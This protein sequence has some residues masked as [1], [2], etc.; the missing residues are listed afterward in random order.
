MLY[1]SFGTSTASA[2]FVT[3]ASRGPA[4]KKSQR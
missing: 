3:A 4:V 2:R 1:R